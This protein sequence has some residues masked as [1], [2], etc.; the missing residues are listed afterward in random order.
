MHRVLRIRTV[1]KLLAAT[2]Y[3]LTFG[4]IQ[5]LLKVSLGYLFRINI[6]YTWFTSE[7]VEFES[8]K[9][10]GSQTPNHNAPRSYESMLSSP[11][12]FRAIPDGMCLKLFDAMILVY[13][14]L[15]I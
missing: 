10:E 4:S 6:K 9:G 11:C 12:F 2:V 8:G 15:N 7:G 1:L 3:E 14:E 13:G 5:V